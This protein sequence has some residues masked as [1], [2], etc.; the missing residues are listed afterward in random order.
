M[1]PQGARSLPPAAQQT[2]E[3][4]LAPVAKLTRENEF[5]F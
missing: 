3:K 1:C 2:I 4:K 5:F